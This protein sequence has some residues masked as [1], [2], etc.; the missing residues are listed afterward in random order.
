MIPLMHHSL[1]WRQL[2]R[3]QRGVAV[4]ASP[5]VAAKRVV[6]VGLLCGAIPQSAAHSSGRFS[7]LTLTGRGTLFLSLAVLGLLQL[8]CGEADQLLFSRSSMT[9]G[10]QWVRARSGLQRP[11]AMRRQIL[12]SQRWWPTP[13]PH[14]LMLPFRGWRSRDSSPQ[15]PHKRARRCRGPPAVLTTPAPLPL[16][17]IHHLLL[18]PTEVVAPLRP[19]RAMGIVSWAHPPA[20]VTTTTIP[21]FPPALRPTRAMR[22]RGVR[23]RP[24]PLVVQQRSRPLRRGGWVAS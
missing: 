5:K 21:L 8:L 22:R 14:P 24:V 3:R 7:E 9:R 16:L 4:S 23:H 12:Q 10:L 17:R 11:S 20:A 1:P 2:V 15:R 18:P 6:G 19:T 13:L